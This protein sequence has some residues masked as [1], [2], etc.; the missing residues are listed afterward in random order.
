M[1]IQVRSNEASLVDV[2]IV[3]TGRTRSVLDLVHEYRDRGGN[4]EDD[5][6]DDD[7]PSV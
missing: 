4:D 1:E 3:R 5:D 2:R 6:E 7:E